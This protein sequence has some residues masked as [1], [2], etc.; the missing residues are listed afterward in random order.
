MRRTKKT[1]CTVALCVAVLVAVCAIGAV[2]M[3]YNEQKEIDNTLQ[4]SES[5]MVLNEIFNEK[6]QWVAGETKQKEVSFEN[7]GEIDQ[8]L[9]FTVIV[10]WYE[11][12]ENGEWV[13]WEEAA[14]DTLTA[15]TINY[16]EALDEQWTL[17][18]G[19]YYY[20]TVISPGEETDLVMTSVTFSSEV[21]NGGYGTSLDYSDKRYSLTINM[22]AIEVN[23]DV[24]IEDWNV[25]CTM[26]DDGNI[27]WSPN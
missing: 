27:T 12:D 8:L 24:A 14:S 15:V 3:Y 13:E 25:V 22:E 7:T 5:E 4:T 17:L 11:Q 20:N 10:Q 21:D 19:Y 16:T 6:D 18:D 2:W 26:G 1:L 23:A 9:R